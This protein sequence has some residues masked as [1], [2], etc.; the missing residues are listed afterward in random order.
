MGGDKNVRR[1]LPGVRAVLAF[2]AGMQKENGSLGPLPWWRYMDWAAEWSGGG[3]PEEEDGSS[4]PFD[5]LLV[6]AYRWAAGLEAGLGVRAL[7]EVYGG[8]ERQLRDTAQKLY[9]DEG[10]RLYADTPRRQQFSQHTNTMAVLSDVT[11]GEPARDLM[12]RS[13][14]AP[15]LAE[16]GL[17]FRYYQHCA[18]AKVGEGDGYLD[19]LGD[20]RIDLQTRIAGL[21][22]NATHHSEQEQSNPYGNS[23]AISRTG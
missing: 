4:A 16:P 9:W 11:V 20:W 1:M 13:L 6:M 15:G 19:R 7:A 18:L 8:R 21:R 3:P 2:F 23:F 10:K 22:M 14:S 17:F 12:L 5:M